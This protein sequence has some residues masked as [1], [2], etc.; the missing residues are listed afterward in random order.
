MTEDVYV[1]LR[2]AMAA[3]QVASTTGLPK[4]LSLVLL[5]FLN[6]SGGYFHSLSP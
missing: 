6:C 2:R 4:A 5:R 1:G 3:G